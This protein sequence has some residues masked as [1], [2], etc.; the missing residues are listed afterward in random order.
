MKY[1][2]INGSPR[3]KNTYEIIKQAA[4]NLDGE[5]E[6]IHLIEKQIPMCLGCMNCINIG[7]DK[8]PHSDKVR[9]II[10]K[11]KEC[12]GIIIASPVYA[13]NVSA[14]LKNLFDFEFFLI[15]FV[16][17]LHVL[18]LLVLSWLFLISFFLSF[19]PI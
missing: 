19:H 14:L 8:C 13:L 4:S 12:D 11:M 10:E 18:I 1:L 17:F 7:E 6:E 3:R 2:I 9:P 5:F 15:Q 16:D